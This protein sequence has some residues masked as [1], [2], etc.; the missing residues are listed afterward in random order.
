MSTVLFFSVVQSV[1]TRP[2]GDQK[3]FAIQYDAQMTQAKQ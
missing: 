2:R 3:V 1:L